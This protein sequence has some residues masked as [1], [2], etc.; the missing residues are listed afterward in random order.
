MTFLD[1]SE[2]DGKILGINLDLVV[3]YYLD[4]PEGDT[5]TLQMLAAHSVFSG[6]PGQIHLDG[7]G[8]RAFF[9]AIR[10]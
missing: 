8:R 5:V 1:L 4:T 3:T 2:G 10:G 7:E 9:D 6:S